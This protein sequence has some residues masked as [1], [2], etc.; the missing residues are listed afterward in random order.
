LYFLGGTGAYKKRAKGIC[1]NHDSDYNAASK[2]AGISDWRLHTGLGWRTCDHV[3]FDKCADLCTNTFED[4]THFSVAANCCFPFKKSS[5]SCK[6]SNNDQD[7]TSKY[8]HFS[9][10]GTGSKFIFTSFF[11][12]PWLLFSISN[13]V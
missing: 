6:I 3:S 10:T 7:W 4:C 12:Q 2:P 1:E 13:I 8:H 11:Y 9:N 5:S